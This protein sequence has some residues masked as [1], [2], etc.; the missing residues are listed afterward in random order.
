MEIWDSASR[1]NP[2]TPW[3]SN[4]WVIKFRRVAPARFAAEVMALLRKA[5]S[6]SRLESQLY[7]SR[8]Q[9]LPTMSVG[10]FSTGGARGVERPGSGCKQEGT[11]AI[12]SGKTAPNLSA[13]RGLSA[14]ENEN[15]SA[16]KNSARKN[17][18]NRWINRGGAAAGAVGGCSCGWGYLAIS[19]EVFWF[20]QSPYPSASSEPPCTVI[21]CALWRHSSTQL[22]RWV[23]LTRH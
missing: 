12:E 17:S 16:N 2:V 14:F 3:G 8:M 20:Q 10:T 18:A 22:C 9:C 23:A 19:V 13:T 6:S 4:R 15:N 5:S 21:S 1:A 11:L 7:S